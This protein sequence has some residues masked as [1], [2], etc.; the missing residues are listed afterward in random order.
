[1]KKLRNGLVSA[2][3]VAALVLTG[4]AQ[5]AGSEPA[6]SPAAGGSSK[7]SSMAA[8]GGESKA[9]GGEKPKVALLIPGV[10]GDK[11]FFDSANSGMEM[12]AGQGFEVKTVEMGQDE[13][14]WVPTMTDI[15]EQDYDIIVTGPWSAEDAL[16]EVAP[17][18]PDKKYLLFDT[19]F[20]DGNPENVCSIMYDQAELS[21]LTG[22]LAAKVSE[23][24][25][26]LVKNTGVIGFVGGMDIPVINDFMVNY[27]KGAQYVN[28]DIKVAV[29]YVGDFVDSAAGKEM[30]LAQYNNQNVDIIFQ[31]AS[32]AGLGCIE[33]AK[34]ADRY[35]IGVDEDQAAIFAESDPEMAG[36]IVTSALKRVGNS[37]SAAVNEEMENGLPWGASVTYGLDSGS[38]GLAD[39]E[40]YQ[41][42]VPQDIR[43]YISELQAKIL[44]GDIE[45]ITAFGMSA[46]EVNAVKNSA[47]P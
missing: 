3:L 39:N 11:S 47:K 25:M 32:Q 9:A 44:N 14:K 36:H 29:S 12:L 37:I 6:A 2:A 30:A 20:E 34:E 33:A 45:M 35:V 15:S 8:S 23:S 42:L 7:A 13:T 19:E 26:P 16:W 4:C 31:S 28:P 18:F 1:M 22:A 41:S 27:I 24:D 21:F 46:E 5:N 17:Q 10:L 43:D 40:Y 38:I